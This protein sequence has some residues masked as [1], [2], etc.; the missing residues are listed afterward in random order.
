MNTNSPPPSQFVPKPFEN[1]SRRMSRRRIAAYRNKA[2]ISPYRA[3]AYNSV[4]NRIASSND[5]ILSKEFFLYLL[6]NATGERI[7]PYLES[8]QYL[9]RSEF[10][11]SV[12][13]LKAGM[14]LPNISLKSQIHPVPQQLLLINALENEAKRKKMDVSHNTNTHSN[15][16]DIHSLLPVEPAPFSTSIDKLSQSTQFR[17]VAKNTSVNV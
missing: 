3:A 14:V 12:C 10:L 2:A 16:L 6:N 15:R 13:K 4:A 5:V 1:K 11:N 8:H 17:F 9:F 7:F